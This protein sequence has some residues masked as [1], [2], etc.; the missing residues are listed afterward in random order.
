M[1]FSGRYF[2]IFRPIAEKYGAEKTP[3]LDTFHAVLFLG[4]RAK[5]SDWPYQINQVI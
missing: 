2:P 4:D 1:E 5:I 3:H